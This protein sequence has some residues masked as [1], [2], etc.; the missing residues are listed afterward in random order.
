[1]GTD[2]RTISKSKKRFGINFNIALIIILIA[3]IAI[4]GSVNPTFVS[5]NYMMSVVVKNIME[6]GLMALPMTLIVITAGIDL[7]V[8]STMIFSAIAGGMVATSMGETAG[9]LVT[10][11]V[12]A[13][14]GLANGLIIVKLKI[15]ALI[16]T[17]ATFFL[18]R[19]IA[20]G[21][22]HGDSVYS[23]DFTTSV[24]NMDIF[25]IP[26]VLFVFI[27]AAV[28][29]TL[30]LSKTGFG[31]SLYALGLNENATRYSGINADRTLIAIYMISGIVCA[32][33]AF[34]YL[35]RFT[36]VKF[37]VAN[38]MNLKVVTVIVLG[39]TSI[40]GGVGDMKGTII[41]IFIIAVLNS[42]LTVMD[43]PIDVQ[44]I[45][46]GTVLIISLIVYSILG[47]RAKKRRIIEISREDEPK[48]V[49]RA[50][51]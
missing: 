21:I 11:L 23:Y 46:Q 6:I 24:G 38:S 31:R 34:F 50:T 43:I 4:I 27:V 7:S 51:A 36:S 5:Y 30:L 29:F 3:L 16:T 45:I 42:G 13:A 35:G 18:F 33:A 2:T 39:G 9:I 19:G 17:L 22:T 40:L 32:I 12:G 10:L 47:E 28:I 26:L 1:M 49:D 15:N 20:K 41:A 8:G 37:D 14:C 44:T 25:G 48:L